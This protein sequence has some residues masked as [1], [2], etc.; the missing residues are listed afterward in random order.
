MKMTSVAV[1]K[2]NNMNG[3]FALIKKTPFGSSIKPGDIQCFSKY[4][5]STDFQY[6]NIQKNR[7]EINWK[8]KNV[9]KV[10]TQW[11]IAVGMDPTSLNPK[12][13]DHSY[14][15]NWMIVVASAMESMHAVIKCISDN[16][17]LF[18]LW[19]KISMFVHGSLSAPND[20]LMICD[21]WLDAWDRWKN[22][23]LLCRRLNKKTNTINTE[24]SYAWFVSN[25]C[26]E[27]RFHVLVVK[28]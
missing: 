8:M 9:F 4:F 3:T 26:A 24:K 10:L 16:L 19:V 6:R 5:M 7:N 14:K 27:R 2:E 17:L 1:V 12:K 15:I 20:M 22:K 28:L 25:G 23:W 21:K 11:F 13:T 18:G